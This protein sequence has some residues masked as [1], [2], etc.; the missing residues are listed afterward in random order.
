MKFDRPTRKKR[1]HEALFDLPPDLVPHPRARQMALH[2]HGRRPMM[3]KDEIRASAW[4]LRCATVVPGTALLANT[5]L[6]NY[7]CF[8]R[9]VYAD[10]LK[11]CRTCAR[12]FVFYANEQRFWYETLR[13]PVDVDCV[14]CPPCR[15]HAHRVKSAQARY[16]AALH[17]PRL[18]AKHME[19][20]V[21]DALFLFDAGELRN[22]GRL[23]AIKNRAQRELPDYSGT[24]A[25][26]RALAI[27]ATGPFPKS[28]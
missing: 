28:R 25:L 1:R 24:Q 4:Q 18:D 21:D 19:V 2:S 3:G 11:Q 15:K 16:A 13:L 6:Q 12:P 27:V 22:V 7:C 10:V 5:H 26:A 17:L 23:G 20:F 8:P 9:R 14:D